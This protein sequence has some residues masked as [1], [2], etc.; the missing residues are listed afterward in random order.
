MLFFDKT[1]FTLISDLF[2]LEGAFAFASAL[3]LHLRA[4]KYRPEFRGGTL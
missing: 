3:S 4:E 2:F 1:K